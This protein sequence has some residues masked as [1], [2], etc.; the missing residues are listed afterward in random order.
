VDQQLTQID[1]ILVSGFNELQSAKKALKQFDNTIKNDIKQMQ[2]AILTGNGTGAS[3]CVLF[4]VSFSLVL[5]YPCFLFFPS[6]SLF[7]SHPCLF[8]VFRSS[9]DHRGSRRSRPHNRPRK[10]SP[11]SLFRL[12]LLVFLSVLFSPILFLFFISSPPALLLCVVFPQIEGPRHRN[13]LGGSDRRPVPSQLSTNNNNSVSPEKRPLSQNKPSPLFQ[14]LSPSSSS[15]SKTV[16][17]EWDLDA[18]PHRSRASSDF[19]CTFFFFFFP[20]LFPA[21]SSPLFVFIFPLLLLQWWIAAK[22]N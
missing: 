14:P 17:N 9:L 3:F 7:R 16:A 8:F 10:P 20:L 21:G 22:T 15:S 1:S 6:S 19:K 5:S 4:D 13:S 18:S 12:C 2:S 11:P